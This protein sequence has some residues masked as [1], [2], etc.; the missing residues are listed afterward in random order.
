MAARRDGVG[1]DCDIS[2]YET[3][4]A[5]LSYI[6]TWVATA[7]YVPER[8]EN[9]AHPSIVPF[10]NFATSDGWVVVACAK[11]KFWTSLVEVLG[12]PELAADVRF[13]D[14]PSR[15]ADREALLSI[16]QEAFLQRPTDEWIERLT[17]AGV[18]CARVNDVAAALVDPQAEFRDAVVTVDHPTFGSVRQVASPLHVGDAALRPTRAPFRGEHTEAILRSLCRYSDQQLHA[19]ADAGVFGDDPPSGVLL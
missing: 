2:L 17:T 13:R 4:L 15:F 7:G 8:V 9:S 3:S 11:P 14:M 10:Q 18:P 16:L 12:L 5:E 19:L 1:C 6:A